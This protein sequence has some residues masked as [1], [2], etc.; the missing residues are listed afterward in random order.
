MVFQ[1]QSVCYKKKIQVMVE[2]GSG[3]K[4]GVVKYI[5]E[6][7]FA[8]GIEWIGVGFDKPFGNNNTVST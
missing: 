8:P 2:L 5:G 4:M 1:V 6:T 3:F 7:E